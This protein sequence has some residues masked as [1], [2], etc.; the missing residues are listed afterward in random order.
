MTTQEEFDALTMIEDWVMHE[1]E[2]YGEEFSIEDVEPCED[3]VAAY[4]NF[5]NPKWG[6]QVKVTNVNRNNE[7]DPRDWGKFHVEL[8]EDNW[9]ECKYYD[10]QVKYFWMALLS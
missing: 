2:D 6:I 3:Q 8:G 4:I 1:V 10:W 7:E 9:E 5:K